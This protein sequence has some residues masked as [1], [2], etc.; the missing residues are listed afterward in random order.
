MYLIYLPIYR[1]PSQVPGTKRF[2]YFQTKIVPEDVVPIPQGQQY[3]VLFNHM[4]FQRRDLQALMPDNTFY[5]AI[6]RNP[7]DRFA[8]SFMYY[9]IADFLMKRFNLTSAKDAL[10]LT[11]NHPEM[12]FFTRPEVY[13]SLA[14][15]TG[16]GVSEQRDVQAVRAHIHRLERDLD[17]ILVV[18]YF[19]ESMVLLKRKACL[20]MRDIV[21]SVQNARQQGQHLLFRPSLTQQER[22]AFTNFQM[23][24]VLMYNHFYQRFW[25]LVYAEDPDFFLEV[26]RFKQIRRTVEDFCRSGSLSQWDFITVSSS[27]WNDEFTVTTRECRLM[28]TT[29]LDMQTFLIHRARQLSGIKG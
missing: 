7:E 18:E 14:G 23:A 25:G 19:D 24:D 28:A 1:S 29:E 13:N 20:S 10:M 3:H 5:F 4:I 22:L 12:F 8:S 15:D 11:V 27:V 9:G 21:Y 17:L 16:L 6:M 26:R 2:N